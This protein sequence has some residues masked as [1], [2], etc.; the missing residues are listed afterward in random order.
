MLLSLRKNG[1]TFLFKEVTGFSRN[2]IGGLLVDAGALPAIENMHKPTALESTEESIFL[3][4][5]PP[6]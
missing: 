6:P 5:V 2:E 1:L 4:Q 3:S